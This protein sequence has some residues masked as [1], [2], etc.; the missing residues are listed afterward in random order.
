MSSATSGYL[1]FLAP[2]LKAI[3]NL[4]ERLAQLEQIGAQR[5]QVIAERDRALAER[6]QELRTRRDESAIKEQELADRVE[7]LQ[8]QVGE[9]EARL[10]AADVVTLRVE[11][12]HDVALQSMTAALRA[13]EQPIA[14]LQAAL[15]E[16]RT[17]SI[18]KLRQRIVGLPFVGPA[19]R[20][21]A[22]RAT[23]RVTLD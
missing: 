9:L 5:D 2:H 1:R 3:G 14:Q 18:V 22:R 20:W 13:S 15:R 16:L 8:Q 11:P 21:L 10:V 4:H 7:R 19:V 6:D 12:A 23:G 17:S